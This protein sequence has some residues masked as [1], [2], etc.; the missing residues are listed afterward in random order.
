MGNQY[1]FA[2]KINKLASEKIVLF[3]SRTESISVTA[4]ETGLS[5][6]T[7]SSRFND[8][9]DIISKQTYSKLPT[10][11]IQIG[12][13]N[14]TLNSNKTKCIVI[15]LSNSNKAIIEIVDKKSA[16][17]VYPV[18]KKYVRT[19]S[20]ILTDFNRIYD[21]LKLNGFINH[22][23]IGD[24]YFTFSSNNNNPYYQN[25][26]I[27]EIDALW[28][29]IKSGIGKQR[30][31]DEIQLNRYLKERIFRYNNNEDKLYK[32]IIRLLRRSR[33]NQS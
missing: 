6:R 19:K 18:I 4:N 27:S 15:I 11:E 5:K 2:A 8:I 33:H 23:P 31:I 3:F 28:R 20:V 24:K 26:E 32:A 10:S 16:Q 21:Q 29:S 25:S 12:L 14:I 1:F 7:V 22:K 30:L 9:R 13:H 17:F